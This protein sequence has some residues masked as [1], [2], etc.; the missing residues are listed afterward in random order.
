MT[1]A[2]ASVVVVDDDA[3]VR[4]AL[5]RHLVSRGHRVSCA[6]DGHGGI[7]IARLARPDVVLL[8]LELPDVHGLDVLERLG[9]GPSTAGVPVVVLT[10]STEEEMLV[11]ALRRG[12]HDFVAK[13]PRWPVLDARLGGAIR[14]K[15]LQDELRAA[16]EDLARQAATDPLT[17]LPNRRQGTLLLERARASCREAVVLKIDVDRFKQINDTLGHAAGDEAL[18]EVGQ[19]LRGAL[20]TDDELARWGGDE[21][22]AVL[23]DTRLDEATFAAERLRRAV[24]LHP[25]LVGLGGVSVSVGVARLGDAGVEPAL[26]SADGA[27]YAAKGA[28]RDAVRT[29]G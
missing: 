10:G 5:E 14:V 13:P 16:N 29:G 24:A 18:R 17:G 25:P 19:A 7:T 22:V 1:G 9:A 21:F 12:A 20:R 2:A 4:T 26:A 8:D 23:H 11:E 3:V 6:A 27:M 15:R 28:G